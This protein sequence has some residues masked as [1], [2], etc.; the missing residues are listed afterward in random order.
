MDRNSTAREGLLA[1]GCGSQGVGDCSRPQAA[2]GTAGQELLHAEMLLSP[3]PVSSHLCV[4]SLN[5]SQSAGHLLSAPSCSLPESPCCPHFHTHV[6]PRPFHLMD[7][8]SVSLYLGSQFVLSS[9]L[10]EPKTLK[11]QE[12][13][14]GSLPRVWLGCLCLLTATVQPWPSLGKTLSPVQLAGRG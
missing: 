4:S 1:I 12:G 11:N 14:L 13:E 10:S 9:R 3:W 2:G 7:F 6:P 8:F 5:P